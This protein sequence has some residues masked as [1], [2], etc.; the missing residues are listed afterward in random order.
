LKPGQKERLTTWLVTE[1]PEL[2]A[3]LPLL[4]STSGSTIT[5]RLKGT[6][7]KE[8]E[9]TLLERSEHAVFSILGGDRTIAL[10]LLPAVTGDILRSQGTKVLNLRHL[11]VEFVRN[12]LAQQNLFSLDF[13]KPSQV[14][15]DAAM[16]WL[17]QFWT[18]ASTS[19]GSVA[20]LAE[21][22]H[23]L[24]LLP[25][26][27]GTM[28]Q[29]S[30]GVFIPD[31]D[32]AG[33]D[34]IVQALK[35]LHVPFLHSKIPMATV[36]A[37]RIFLD[38]RGLWRLV[39]AGNVAR[40]LERSRW[41][42][43]S[44]IHAD[45]LMQFFCRA[46]PESTRDAP[47]TDIQRELLKALP[48]FPS[49]EVSARMKT[50]TTPVRADE[51]STQHKKGWFKGFHAFGSSSKASQVLTTTSNVQPCTSSL[52][53]DAV[54]YGIRSSMVP[55]AILPI[56]D[57]AIYLHGSA[58]ELG[59]LSY[60]SH[61]SAVPTV[62]NEVEILSL[63]A[64]NFGS[65]P[66]MLQ[67]ALMEKMETIGDALPPVVVKT[68]LRV[69]FVP[70][71]DGTTQAPY[72]LVDPSSDLVRLF[73]GM[74]SRI[75][76][77]LPLKSSNGETR[78]FLDQ[79]R[80]IGLLKSKLDDEL[81]LERIQHISDTQSVTLARQLLD[82]LY[83]TSYDITSTD[84]PL[85][86][87]WIPTRDGL[88]GYDG[89][90]HATP[91]HRTE[92][93]DEVMPVVDEAIA[94]TPSLQRKFGWNHPVNFSTMAMQLEKVLELRDTPTAYRKLRALIQELSKRALTDDELKAIDTTVAGKPWIPISPKVLSKV[95]YAVFEL[96][97]PV[98]EF[99]EIPG[100]LAEDEDIRRFLLRM[101]CS[102]GLVFAFCL[103]T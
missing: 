86:L 58:E 51:Q 56:L 27:D 88:K 54:V 35:A 84:I 3:D 53:S 4:S 22:L 70:V 93:F 33:Q 85:D 74:N 91:E 19:S 95:E 49:L 2:L 101:G 96:V 31:E 98:G 62:L 24:Y 1:S 16:D 103:T 6:E 26:H 83:Q 13:A 45:A 14:A 40:I 102:E 89:C 43:G 82:L 5:L 42:K 21:D 87:K 65:Q 73:M 20:R 97:I 8:G 80:K 52:P 64:E 75:P 23:T 28:H 99:C 7:H 59:I 100:G 78:S 76:R 60:I 46:L 25:A 94:F 67:L 10:H 12:Y 66:Q 71:L 61:P 92:L 47:L 32:Y 36:Q 44:D 38:D 17:T 77:N 29:V 37:M 48:I 72:T 18:W 9:Y 68:L 79:I 34:D 90:L 57:S 81:I 63:A 15:S 41:E 39:G 30:D 50:T 55:N 69:P 11:D